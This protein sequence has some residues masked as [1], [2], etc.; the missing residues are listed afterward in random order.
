MNRGAASRALAG[1]AMALSL[2][3]G[4]SLA[5]AGSDVRKP[6][7]Y[8]G[9]GKTLSAL[10]QQRLTTYR[11]QLEVQQRAQQ[12]QLNQGSIATQALNG[13]LQP[14]PN[15]A[16]ASRNLSQT[17]LEL[18]RVNGLLNRAR[19]NQMLALPPA[20]VVKRFPTP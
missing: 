5:H 3:G 2:L 7:Y 15:P 9:A 17:Q 6:Y 13:P 8:V 12:L 1:A 10:D 14:Y 4:M 19:T 16:I 20:M 11:D 18:D